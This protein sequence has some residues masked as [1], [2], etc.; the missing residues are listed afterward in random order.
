MAEYVV[1][2]R[3]TEKH[4]SGRRFGSEPGPTKFLKVPSNRY[5]DPAQAIPRRQW[6]DEVLLKARSGVN[7]YTGRPTGDILVFIHGYNNSQKIVL[8]RHRRLQQDLEE[9]GYQ[10]AVISYDWPSADIGLNYL[11]DRDDAKATALRLRNDCINLFSSQQAAGCEINVHVIGHSTGAYVI[12]QAFADADEKTSI[13]NRPWRASQVILIGG[14]IS[15]R[16]LS[17]SDSRSKS[18]YRHCVRLTNYQNP[19]DS[20]LKLSNT[21]RIGLAP[22]VGRVGL[23]DNA[24]PEK[25]VNIN[26]GPYFSTLDEDSLVQGVDYYGNFKHSW[27]IGDKVFAA[28]LLYT[29]TGDLDRRVIPTRKLI[30]GELCLVREKS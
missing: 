17:A 8:Q 4:G 1:C 15:Q 20:V 21:K 2:V 12:R 22:R 14:D 18:L 19:Y 16:S 3:N 23:P 5:P 30:N 7:E 29:L 11:E 24:H 9:A 26:C 10:G 6:V 13:K 25:A 28:D 27:H